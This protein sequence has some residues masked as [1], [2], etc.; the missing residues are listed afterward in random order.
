MQRSDFR[1]IPHP[2]KQQYP[3]QASVEYMPTGERSTF[4]SVEDCYEIINLA[5]KGQLKGTFMM[6]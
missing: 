1:L 6:N 4:F 3:D 2:N 5:L